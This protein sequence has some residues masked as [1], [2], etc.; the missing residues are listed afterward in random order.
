MLL[1]L[2]VSGIAFSMPALAADEACVKPSR[3]EIPNGA[4][5]SM[6]A[7]LAG[8]QA[9][10][11]FQSS[12]MKYMQCLEAK[13]LAAEAKAKIASDAGAKDA[14]KEDYSASINAY[15]AAVSAEED[16]AGD[17]N[18]SLRAYKKAQK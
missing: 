1:C 6:E 12:N 16:V 7:M 3:P 8:Q 15:N 2:V 18:V 9:V 10:K 4:N 13:Y 17:F 14:A 5:A 11:A